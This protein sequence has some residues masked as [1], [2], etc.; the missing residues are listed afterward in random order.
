M[1]FDDLAT[2]L[3]AEY[4]LFL[5]ALTGRYQQMRAPGIEITPREIVKL[6]GKAH[7]LANTFYL[8]AERDVSDYLQPMLEDASESARDG[9]IV[10]KKEVL[11]RLRA[12]LLENLHQVVKL[13]RTGVGGV[14][15]ML[16][17]TTGAIGLLVQR[18][19]GTIQFKATDA[20][21]RK[22]DA[23]KLF[24][25]LARDFA[26]QSWLDVQADQFIHTEHNLMQTPNGRIFS[27]LGTDGYDSFEAVRSEIFHIN[28]NQIMVP[29]VSS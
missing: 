29:H 17:G 26:Y 21:G 12:G 16:T 20:A 14:G 4:A 5:F 11:S 10:R 24:K 13:A 9:L 25:T 8:I 18:Q 7:E 15:S 2:R 22:W 27:L 28:S 1:V 3:S 6:N 23:E 19:A